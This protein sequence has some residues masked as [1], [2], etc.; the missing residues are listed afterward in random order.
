VV[1]GINVKESAS[2]VRRFVKSQ[3]LDFP[4]VLD[5]QGDLARQWDVRIYPS[6]VL[7]GSDGQARWRVI[8]DLDWSGPEAA[9]WISALQKPVSPPRR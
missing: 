8:G 6:T 2:T 5:P 4:V 7:L 1:I 3:R 9:A